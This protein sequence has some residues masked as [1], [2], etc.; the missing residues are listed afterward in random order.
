MSNNISDRE[1]QSYIEKT[2]KKVVRTVDTKA[3]KAKVVSKTR[4]TDKVVSRAKNAKSKEDT[5]GKLEELELMPDLPVSVYRVNEP[6]QRIN[7]VKD[8]EFFFPIAVGRN[9]KVDKSIQKHKIKKLPAEARTARFS[10]IEDE[11]ISDIEQR[12]QAR[13]KAKRLAEQEQQQAEQ[14]RIEAEAAQRRKLLM[15]AKVRKIV[16]SEEAAQR[17]EIKEEIEEDLGIKNKKRNLNVLDVS[18]G[19][20]ILD[21]YPGENSKSSAK[22]TRRLQEAEEDEDS[23][24]TEEYPL[25]GIDKKALKSI[26]SMFG[27]RSDSIIELLDVGNSD[28]ALSLIMKT[29]LSTLVDTMPAVEGHV[30]RSGGQKGVYQ[31]T[32]L[33]SQLRETCADIQAYRDRSNLGNKV[34]ERYLRP[35]FLDIAVQITRTWIELEAGAASKM[36]K[37][38]MK[39]YQEDY[40]IPMKRGIADYLMKQYEDVSSSLVQSLN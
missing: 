20:T 28:G 14:D 29:L 31:L 23:L 26:E 21:D 16:K 12:K 5:I 8:D 18:G 9:A 40:L 2:A 32:Q 39:K 10:E 27:Q 11:V 6:K 30:R 37:E 22:K 38:D 17:A 4:Q 13:L 7:I 19:S 35:A 15:R 25:K 34:V 3:L 36:S 1:L 24:L 33:S